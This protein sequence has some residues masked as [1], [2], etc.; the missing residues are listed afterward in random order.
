M[1]KVRISRLNGLVGNGI[2]DAITRITKTIEV[3]TTPDSLIIREIE[4]T[5]VVLKKTQVL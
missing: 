5:E 2:D 1:S 3:E 4:E